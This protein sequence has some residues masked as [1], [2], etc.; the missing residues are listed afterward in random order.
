FHTSKGRPFILIGNH[1]Y[2]RMSGEMETEPYR[3]IAGETLSYWLERIFDILGSDT[4]VLVMGDF[5]DEPFNRSVSE[6]ALSTHSR[7]KVINARN[8][9]LFN[10]M[11]SLMGRGFGTFFYDNF[12]YIFDQFMV[13]KSMLKSNALIKPVQVS[14]GGYRV[15][16][17][18]QPEMMAGGDYPKPKPFGRPSS[19]SSY[20]PTGYSDHFP[21][22]VYLEE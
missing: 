9:R 11:Y 8:P 20:D 4:P 3:I 22:S 14:T 12:P 15:N 2:S 5:N 7:M 21:I 1:W 16:I 10:L 17:V 18:M 6:Y 13:T 19:G